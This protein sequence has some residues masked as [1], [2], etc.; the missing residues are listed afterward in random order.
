MSPS[1]PP[2]RALVIEDETPLRRAFSRMMSLIATVELAASAEEG[3]TLLESCEVDVVLTDHDLGE[4]ATGRWLLEQVLLV[5]PHARRVMMSA[6][7][8]PLLNAQRDGL[9]H[10]YLHKPFSIDELHCAVVGEPT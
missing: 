5:Q 2:L 7:I 8:E 10:A 6:S 9:L 1:V 3:I 4:G